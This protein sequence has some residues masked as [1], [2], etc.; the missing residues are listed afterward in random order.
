M[1]VD[2]FDSPIVVSV[3]ML[4]WWSCAIAEIGD[5]HSS[6]SNKLSKLTKLPRSFNL[7]DYRVKEVAKAYRLE[8]VD[9][10]SKSIVFSTAVVSSHD[11]TGDGFAVMAIDQGELFYASTAKGLTISVDYTSLTVTQVAGPLERLTFWTNLVKSFND[12]FLIVDAVIFCWKF[13]RISVRSLKR[14]WRQKSPVFVLHY[15][16]C[17]LLSLVYFADMFSI[18][19]P[20]TPTLIV[21]C[22]PWRHERHR[23]K[24]YKLDEE[25]C[26]WV[27]VEDG[28]EDRVFFL[29]DDCSFSLSAKEFSGCKGNSVYFK[30]GPFRIDGFL[31]GIDGAIF[32]LKDRTARHLFA[33]Y[34]KILWPSPSWVK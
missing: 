24:V 10:F 27:E 9:E 18:L 7:L 2:S 4:E 6:L 13:N 30:H 1:P 34:S 15:A 22:S 29:G 33:E 28:L 3:K 20:K 16:V 14:F 32:D 5:P 17:E 31:P 26:E 12:L 23:F 11:V 8:L 19:R 25:M 21:K